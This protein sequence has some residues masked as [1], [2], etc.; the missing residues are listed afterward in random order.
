MVRP[1]KV[2]HLKRECLSA[3]VARASEGDRQSD[4]PMGDRLLPWDHS[5]KW[6]WAAL[7]LLTGKPHL[8]KVS[9][10][11]RLMPLPPSMRALVSQVIPT[12]GSTMRG[13]LPG[14]GML[15]R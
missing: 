13:N 8:A 9:R 3:V 4:P 11:M 12:S 1:R 15:S 5:V 6:M 10:Y 14:L 7:E 2:D